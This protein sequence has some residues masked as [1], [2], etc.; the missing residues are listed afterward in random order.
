M[1]C[2]YRMRPHPMGF[3]SR[4]PRIMNLLVVDL[5]NVYRPAEMIAAGFEYKSIG[6]R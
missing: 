2:P 5:R 1:N 4:P 6:R 3:M